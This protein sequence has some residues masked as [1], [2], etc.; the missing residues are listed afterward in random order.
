MGVKGAKREKRERGLFVPSCLEAPNSANE[1][2]QRPPFSESLGEQEVK[3]NDDVWGS[4]QE[5]EKE[6]KATEAECREE[7]RALSGRV[8]RP[9]ATVNE[10]AVNE[11]EKGRREGQCFF[12]QNGLR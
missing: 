5:G 8:G 3:R 4:E 1:P 12:Y 7:G 2:R 11:K 10:K 6:W 9:G